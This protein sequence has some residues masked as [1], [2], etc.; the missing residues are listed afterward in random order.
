MSFVHF[1]HFLFAISED[2]CLAAEKFTVFSMSE[3]YLILPGASSHR[4]C[5]RSGFP[6]VFFLELPLLACAHDPASDAIL[7]GASSPVLT[8][9]LTTYHG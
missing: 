2:L 1:D 6:I 5:S 4:M 9:C 3:G 8:I 7:P